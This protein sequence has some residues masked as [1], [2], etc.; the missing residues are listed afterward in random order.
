[1]INP[2]DIHIGQKLR[3]IRIMAGMSQE[4]VGELVGVSLQ[5]IRKYEV[6]ISRV[7]AS[8]LYELSQVFD[9]PINSFFDDYVFDPDFHNT[10]FKSEADCQKLELEKDQEIMS[11]VRAFNQIKSFEVRESLISFVKSIAGK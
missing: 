9:K 8:R 2:L 7:S 3:K 5:Q 11:L 6:G 1:M 4:K 10:E